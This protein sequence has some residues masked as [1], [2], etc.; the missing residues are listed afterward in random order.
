MKTEL[1]TTFLKKHTQDSEKIIQAAIQALKALKLARISETLGLNSGTIHNWIT[2]KS[3]LSGKRAAE[4]LLQLRGE[5]APRAKKPV[6]KPV[7]SI[8]KVGK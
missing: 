2:Q 6:K 3:K 7:S 4:I 5:G 1:N 8:K